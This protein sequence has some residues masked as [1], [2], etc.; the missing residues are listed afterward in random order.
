MF[1]N[2]DDYQLF[3]DVRCPGTLAG[4]ELCASQEVEDIRSSFRT[5]VYDALSRDALNSKVPTP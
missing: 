1:D 3:L 4:R 2:E 5:Y